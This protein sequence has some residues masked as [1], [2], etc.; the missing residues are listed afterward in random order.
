MMCR[1]RWDCED[2]TIRGGD[3]NLFLLGAPPK[4]WRNC[5]GTF[6]DRRHFCANRRRDVPI[7]AVG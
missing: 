7:G 1:L 5:R 3:G 6:I 2:A 4:S